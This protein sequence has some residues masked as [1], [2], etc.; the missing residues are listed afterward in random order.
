M[1]NSVVKMILLLC[2]VFSSRSIFAVYPKTEEDF[3]SLPPY[4]KARLNYDTKAPQYKQWDQ[5]MGKET[6]LHVHHYCAA[7]FS[8]DLARRDYEQRAFLLKTAISN[9]VMFSI[10]TTINFFIFKCCIMSTR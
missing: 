1:L 4:C 9:I 8:L 2:L 10:L 7:L 3:A 5:R 6:F